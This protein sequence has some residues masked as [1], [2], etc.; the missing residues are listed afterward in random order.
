MSI[1]NIKVLVISHNSFSKTLNNGKTL[2]S[3]FASFPKHNIAQLFFS[4][5]EYPD[6][7]FC[8]NYFKI[9]DEDVLKNLISL[10]KKHG[11][12]VDNENIK[13]SEN[14]IRKHLKNRIWQLLQTVSSYV[15][16]FRDLLWKTGFWKIPSLFKW[17]EQFNA[18]LIFYCGGNSG[19]SHDIVL[20]LKNKYNVPLVSYFTDDYLVSPLNRNIID[21]IHR[22]K[23]KKFYYRT[24]ENSSLLFVIGEL[25]AQVY[26]AY[27]QKEFS[28]IMNSV[29]STKFDYYNKFKDRENKTIRIVY[30]GGLHLNRWR[31]ISYLS[32]II[33]KNKSFFSI[34]PE[35]HVY[36]NSKI[37]STIKES[38]QNN[39]IIIRGPLTGDE[40]IKEMINADIL[41]HVESDDKYNKSL[42][43][44]SV[45]TK[46]PEYLLTK[47]CVLAYGPSEVA[48]MRLLQDNNIGILIDSEESEDSVLKKITSLIENKEKRMEIGN[49]GY[50]YA[51]ENFD[52][53]VTKMNF[54][55]KIVEL[56]EKSTNNTQLIL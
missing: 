29:S 22:N 54:I 9:T 16:I 2:E 44:L 43:K 25:M 7:D 31:M 21:K 30:F 51:K 55:K 4:K 38:Y 8:D 15:I 23:M 47:N 1:N 42:T 17:I 40:L 50:K 26:S 53:E 35:I 14:K 24:I 36:T 33:Q 52:S 5:N 45:S 28:P 13:I 27:F 46:I 48:S 20:Y 3:L 6:F 19:F 56:L 12:R 49:K 11:Q 32:C 39:N 37:T 34:I 18:D 41:L 10:N